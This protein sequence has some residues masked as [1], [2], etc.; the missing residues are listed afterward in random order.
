MKALCQELGV[1]Y[2]SRSFNKGAKAGNMNAALKFLTG[3]YVAILDADFL[4]YKNFIKRAMIEFQDD[5]VAIVQFP[6][7]FYNPD[8]T[9]H[10]SELFK[11][12]NDEQWVWY[13][14][15]L[16]IRDS[17]NLGSGLIASK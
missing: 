16:P 14:Q 6:Q 5:D 13:H 10:N 15:V 12:L 3:D 7:T 17:A 9:Q 4:A 2:F 8:P 11:E 1:R